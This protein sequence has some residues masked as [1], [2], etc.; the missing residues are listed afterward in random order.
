MGSAMRRY[1][2]AIDPVTGNA[3]AWNPHLDDIVWT[4]GV[5]NEE[6]YVGG[7]FKNI[8]EE[9]RSYF[10][11][12]DDNT[13]MPVWLSGLT[14]SI[15]GNQLAVSWI[16]HTESDNSHFV[17]E[18]ST[19]GKEFIKVGTVLSKATDGNSSV[20]L[21]YTFNTPLHKTLMLGFGGLLC[22]FA[23]PLFK[24][25]KKNYTLGMVFLLAG[26]FIFISGCKK[27][28]KLESAGEKVMVRI[29]QVDRNG[30]QTFSNVV[31]ANIKP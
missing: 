22:L 19:D 12:I 1:I 21:K 8:N 17:I 11:T 5:K 13:A 30:A 6:V 20:P 18:M 9:F 28:D 25:K 10:A 2:A 23:L 31:I 29:V 4:L 15:A 27:I 7:K 16:T 24:N 14:A 3:T 26:V